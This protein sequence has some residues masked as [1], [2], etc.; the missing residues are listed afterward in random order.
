MPIDIQRFS[1]YR[2]ADSITSV[3]NIPVAKDYQSPFTFSSWLNSFKQFNET[4]EIYIDLY[5][6]YLSQWYKIK[7]DIILTNEQIIIVSYISIFYDLKLTYFTQEERRFLTTLDYNKKQDIDIAIPFFARK[8]KSICRELIDLRETIKAQP[9]KLNLGGTKETLSKIIFDAIY[10]SSTST[11]LQPDFYKSDVSGETILNNTIVLIDDLYDDTDYYNLSAY[12]E[13]IDIQSQ[14][15]LDFPQAVLDEINQVQFIVPELSNYLT[16]TPA[17]TPTDIDKLYDKDYINTINNS[18]SSNL[19]LVNLKKLTEQFTGSNY[20]YLS[21]NSL[22][23]VVSGS[24]FTTTSD[25]ANDQNIFNLKFA[26]KQTTDNLY[27]AK[28]VGG[29]YLP[30]RIGVLL[31]NPIQSSFTIDRQK[32]QPN[33]VV[34]F[35]DPAVYPYNSTGVLAFVYNTTVF[36]HT[37]SDQYIYGDIKNDEKL[38]D[39]KGFQS[40]NVSLDTD[41]NNISKPSD[42]VSFFKNANANIWLN[43]DVY[44]ITNKAIFPVSN[45]Q[46]K[47]LIDNNRDVVKF[48]TDV[49]GNSY[50][51]VK[52]VYKIENIKQKDVLTFTCNHFDGFFLNWPRYAGND[53]N[54]YTTFYTLTSPEI[55]GYI[56]SGVVSATY[57]Q[58]STVNPYKFDGYSQIPEFTLSGDYYYIYGG[59]FVDLYCNTIDTTTYVGNVIYDGYTFANEYNGELFYEFP[60]S[61]S[62]L[63]PGSVENSFNLYY[64]YLIDGGMN[65][66]GGRPTFTKPSKFTPLA[67]S[68]TSWTITDTD[69]IIDNGYFIYTGLSGGNVVEYDPFALTANNYYQSTVP[70]YNVTLS[71][72]NTQ[73]STIEG[74]SANKNI[75]AKR[76][77]I[78]GNVYV[79]SGNNTIIDS[80]S[81]ALSSNFVRFPT[82]VTNEINN[83][84]IDFDIIYDTLIIETDNYRIIERI[85]YDYDSG[86]FVG[87][88]APAIYMQR[89]TV[90]QSIEKFG[91]FWYNE[92]YKNILFFD[93]TLSPEVSGT[94]KIIYPKIYKFDI[95]NFDFKQIYPQPAENLLQFS[96]SNYLSSY[97]GIGIFDSYSYIFNPQNCD[98]PIVSYNETTDTYTVVTKV[99]DNGGAYCLQELQFRFIRGVFTLLTNKCYFANQLIRDESYSNSI[100]STFLDYIT[101]VAG[102]NTGVWDSNLG[103]YKF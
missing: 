15:F 82:V 61:D 91:D 4:P 73:Y 36:K 89:G 95:N 40:E 63:W 101:P 52:E 85:N 56:R 47:L 103:L 3:G 28:D 11:D 86:L 44:N 50:G 59:S 90:D 25:S 18:L 53:V 68:A 92:K 27:S 54:N 72:S 49:F 102:L 55:T 81:S 33:T 70:Y 66:Q 62:P 41:F 71:S 16:F 58:L 37:L 83:N 97:Y 6:K 8:I 14:L 84:I 43:P 79:R 94:L 100:T 1:D 80:I 93:T 74:L 78:N 12:S 7:N 20:Y 69:E 22:S 32:L 88:Y 60:S 96:L 65:D 46:L 67:L 35:P 31:Y 34:I 99:Y 5:R 98:K 77:T 42:S 45:R 26:F 57:D 29:F 75:Y 9:V 30:Q 19:N 51:L 39:F 87:S 64:Q 21:T 2:P 10:T 24:L 23:E 76:N 13:Q 38:P 48:R 17:N